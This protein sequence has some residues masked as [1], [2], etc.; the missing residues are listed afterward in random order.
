MTKTPS[1]HEQIRRERRQQ[2]VEAATQVF[3]SK[4]FHAANV[5]EVAAQAG[6]SQGTIYWYF[7]SKESLF[8]AVLLESLRAVS[9]P[10]LQLIEESQLTPLETI[11]QMVR[12]L[13]SQIQNPPDSFRL[14]LSLWTQPE[15]LATGMA[16]RGIQH[17][18][19]EWID[20]LLGTLIQAGMEAG[21]IVPGNPR[22][23]A[24]VLVTV[25]D[26]LAF[27]ALIFP[28]QPLDAQEI[29]VAVMRL[30]RLPAS[31]ETGWSDG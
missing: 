25:L 14:L 8:E 11:Q 15:T 16:Y 22:A 23:L 19:Q 5:S 28:D 27:Q 9:Q 1:R 7:D 30:F 24:L 2:I 29:E 20:G 21:E 10:S 31:Q 26:G 17:L 4:G 18:Y 6:V 3:A 12:H 13:L